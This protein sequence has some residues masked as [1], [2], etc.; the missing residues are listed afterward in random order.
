MSG[1]FMITGLPRSR[2]AWFAVATGALHEPIARDGLEAFAPDWE[3]R[4]GVSDSAAGI[5]LPRIIAEFEPQVLVVERPFEDVVTS[6][7]RYVAV[8]HRLD[9]RRVSVALKALEATLA[10]DHPSILRVR[11]D[12]LCH[13]ETLYECFAWLRVNPPTNLDQLMHMH[14]ESSL[15]WNLAK[16]AEKA[17]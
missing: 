13:I 1:R 6:L 14:I 5:W 3:P 9:W 7:D 15:A 8:T 10:Y 12:D 2:T 11:Y 16:L 4:V 17:A